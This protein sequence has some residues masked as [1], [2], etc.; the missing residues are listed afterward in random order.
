MIDLRS[1]TVTRP[2]QAMLKAMCEA[3]LGDDVLGD[4]PTVQKLEATVAEMAGKET[5]LFVPSGTMSN[6]I[7][8]WLHTKSGDGILVEE[9]SHIFHYEAAAPAMIAGVKTTAVGGQNGIMDLDQLAN[10]FP[11]DDPHCAPVTLVCAEDTANRG[12]GYVY[13][14]ETL[15]AIATAARQNDASTHLDGAR[16]FNAQ[17]KSNLSAARR[18]QYYDT[19]S[20]CFSK[21]LGAPIGSALCMPHAMRRDAVRARKMLGGGMR[22][23]GVIAAAALYALE[24]HVERLSE[25]HDKAQ[26]L[27]EGLTQQG[28]DVSS[29]QTNMV[30]FKH[31]HAASIV[32]QASEQGVAALTAKA[33]TIRLVTHL[34][35]SFEDIDESIATFGKLLEQNP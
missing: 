16:L 35:V 4:E 6:Q 5:A 33:Q 20:I 29:P 31:P 17:I 13:P 14:V 24:N 7:A 11:P 34:D 28:Y 30:F 23:A 27:A 1:D 22:Q 21:G 19:V 10:A 18:T 2:T 3:P 25:D 32:S 9:N 15:D 8:I 26:H 12:G